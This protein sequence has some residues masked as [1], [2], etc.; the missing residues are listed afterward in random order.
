MENCARQTSRL[1]QWRFFRVSL[2]LFV[3][4][5]VSADKLAT[6]PELSEFRT[7]LTC[8]TFQAVLNTFSILWECDSA[9]LQIPGIRY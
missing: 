5:D 1:L 9:P 3:L 7:D 2:R 6:G 4:L 8:F